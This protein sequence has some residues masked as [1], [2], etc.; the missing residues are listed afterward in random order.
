MAGSRDYDA[1]NSEV[2]EV[3]RKI[4]TVRED[5]DTN[6]SQEM[7]F[8]KRINELERQKNNLVNDKLVI[9]RRCVERAKMES[10]RVE[11]EESIKTSESSIAGIE[12]ELKPLADEIRDANSARSKMMTERDRSSAGL[13]Q[14]I[15]KAKKIQNQVSAIMKQIND[16]HNSNNEANMN[17]FG[18]LK[19]IEI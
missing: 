1:V 10:K 3:C 8:E 18:K 11:L 9:E 12:V 6:H 14:E 16:Y 17:R 19:C 5:L 15:E 13:R 4:S 7:N 2:D